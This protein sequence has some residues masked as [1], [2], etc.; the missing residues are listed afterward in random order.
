MLL[1]SLIFSLLAALALHRAARRNP[2]TDP[3]ITAAILILVLILP[4][5]TF[6]PKFTFTVPTF[7]GPSRPPTSSFLPAL[8]AA[9]FLIFALRG[10]C[11]L[12]ALRRWTALSRPLAPLPVLSECLAEAGL[13]GHVAFRLHPQLASPVV[14]G[15]FRPTVYLPD[16]APS[17]PPQTLKMAILH[18]L[19]HLKRRDLWM[20]LLAHLTCLVHWFNPAVWWLRRTFL[21]QCEFACDAC[22]IEKGTDP[23]AYAHALCDLARSASAPPCSLAMTGHAPL[24]ER[25]AFLS[26]GTPPS[27]LLLPALLFL[28]AT[29]AVALSVIRFA[30][31]SPFSNSA[32]A[33][34][35]VP[36]PESELRFSADPFPADR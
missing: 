28:T 11:D 32:P 15:L 30:P 16:S 19:I 7:S 31:G 5:L 18:E 22:L 21:T 4:A 10:L 33:A 6:L 24:R 35:P 20:A 36:A 9:G 23:Q 12:G 25:I 34:R 14:A 13:S 8:W 26:S 1:P 27:S 17:W 2:A 29:S 3:R